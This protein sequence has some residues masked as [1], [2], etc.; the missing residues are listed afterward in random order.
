MNINKRTSRLVVLL[1]TSSQQFYVECSIY[2]LYENISPLAVF[3]AAAASS[4]L[5]IYS[6]L[7]FY[8]IFC[9]HIDRWNLLCA[10]PKLNKERKK[11]SFVK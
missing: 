11:K 7:I 9:P 10:C 4:Q 6:L 1:S 2:I 5:V 3:L 8:K